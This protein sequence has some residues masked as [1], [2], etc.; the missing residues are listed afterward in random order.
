M[1]LTA[2]YLALATGTAAFTISSTSIAEPFRKAVKK[3]SEFFGKLVGCPHC[4]SHWLAAG[5]TLMYRP[6]LVHG[7]GPFD[8]LVTWLAITGTAMVPVLLAKHA[9]AKTLPILPPIPRS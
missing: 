9:T 5:A 4:L 3:R 6:W 7:G 8:W 1:W 2:L